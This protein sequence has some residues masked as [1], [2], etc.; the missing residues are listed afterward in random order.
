MRHL[1]NLFLFV[2][3][4][5]LGYEIYLNFQ[6]VPMPE[7]LAGKTNLPLSYRDTQ[8]LSRKT[9]NYEDFG[10][11]PE[12]NLFHPDRK[13]VEEE[14]VEPE[15]E[16][17]EEEKKTVPPPNF[18][19]TGVIILGEDRRFAYIRNPE[20]ERQD[21]EKYRTGDQIADF[22]VAQILP[23][24]VYLNRGEEQ[25]VVRL[26]DAEKSKKK[27]RRSARRR[28]GRRTNRLGE[29]NDRRRRPA[30][31][32]IPN[33]RTNLDRRKADLNRARQKAREE[34]E[35]KAAAYEEPDTSS[36]RGNADDS[37]ATDSRSSRSNWRGADNSNDNRRN[38]AKDWNFISGSRFN[39]RSP[40]GQ[41]PAARSPSRHRCGNRRR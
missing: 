33:R 19:L 18:T 32:N 15:P 4:G 28:A 26:Y 12:K 35:R 3:V 25:S 30:A 17:P 2:A 8:D 24:R 9:I 13:F 5:M 7:V 29:R 41:Q 23:D 38:N 22:T 39:N 10:V 31:R 11:I 6:P 27:S 14:E 21:A 34:A 40:S 16:P 20:D 1:I 37:G 36:K